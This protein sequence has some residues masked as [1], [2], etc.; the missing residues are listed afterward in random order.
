MALP[1]LQ[2]SVES[3]KELVSLTKGTY[4]Y[5]N[6]MQTQQR[7]IPL[8]GV[9]GTYK[10]WVEVL[11]PFET[12]LVIFKRRIDSIRVSQSKAMDKRLYPAL[13]PADVNMVSSFNGLFHPIAG[14]KVFADTDLVVK[15]STSSLQK[16]NAVRLSLAERLRSGGT[17][18]F[19]TKENVT[20]LIGYFVS[21]EKKYLQEPE[22]ETNATANEYGQAEIKIANA[23]LIEGMP[24]VN[25]HAFSF[26]PGTHE[27]S[28]AKG[29]CLVLGF[30]KRDQV[31]PVYDAAL[32]DPGSKNVDWLFE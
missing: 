23:L 32:N 26:G 3:Y 9:N 20:L 7:K 16:L 24:A 10:T 25:V 31:I 5:A 14:E 11:I 1:L 21:K 27:L 13:E 6:S 12:E 15:A 17:I 8:R 30:V 29:I 19:S 4:L 18:K 28:L 22:L 2:Q